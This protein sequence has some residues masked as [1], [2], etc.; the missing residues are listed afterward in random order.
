M[1]ARLLMQAGAPMLRNC[2]EAV[3]GAGDLAGD[4]GDGVG[5][6]AEIGCR[7]HRLGE[8]GGVMDAPE[9]RLERG[10]RLA[11]GADGI[12]RQ[13]APGAARQMLH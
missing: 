6:A 12:G 1:D 5:I 10:H 2:G 9:R 3:G 8:R 4:R 11:R 13:V 7:Q